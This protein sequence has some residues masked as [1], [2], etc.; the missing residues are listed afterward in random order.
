MLTLVEGLTPEELAH[1]RLTRHE[2]RRHLE[3]A[4]AAAAALSRAARDAM[5]E[6]DFDAWQKVGEGLA[7][8]ALAEGNATQLAIHALGPASLG[9]LRYYRAHHPEL[10]THGAPG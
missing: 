3:S 6:V 1:S 8:D 4:V 2:V 9:W 5:P 10:F 7:K